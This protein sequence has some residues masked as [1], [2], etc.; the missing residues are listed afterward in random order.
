[1]PTNAHNRTINLIIGRGLI[2]AESIAAELRR[3]VA[4]RLAREFSRDVPTD[5][6][7]AAARDE[8]TLFEPLLA[9][10]LRDSELAAWVAGM[11]YVAN[12]LPEIDQKR[13]AVDKGGPP[14]VETNPETEKV[15][16][17]F[18]ELLGGD[19]NE[20]VVEFPMIDKAAESLLNRRIMTR[21]EFDKLADEAK[22][23]AFTVAK[24][25]STAT[26]DKIRDALY[27]SVE[28]GTSLGDFKRRI[29]DTLDESPIG[30]AHLETVYRTNLQTAFSIGRDDLMDNPVVAEVFPYCAYEAIGDSRTRPD[31]WALMTL[32]IDGTNIYRQDDPFWN[33]FSTPWD[34]NC[35]CG[36]RPVTIEYAARAGVKEAIYWLETGEK[37]PLRSRLPD[38]PFRPQ[39]GW[40]TR[41]RLV[42][43]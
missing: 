22:N 9:T 32:G 13:V 5:Y 7:L 4:D 40:G 3:R 20:P 17:L 6:L 18:R 10:N 15:T 34:Y 35:R 16:S 25:S 11:E 8:L 42:A 33:V 23:Q 39:P 21:D 29:K 12:R 26:I 28:E 38:I 2:S 37:P 43:A 19:D 30:P 24:I 41:K 27:T 36:Q 31:H 1:M 14:P